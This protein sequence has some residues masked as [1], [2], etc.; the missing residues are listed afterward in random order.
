MLALVQQLAGHA[1]APSHA[2][3]SSQLATGKET[4]VMKTRSKKRGLETTSTS[5]MSTPMKPAKVSKQKLSKDMPAASSACG[6][7]IIRLQEAFAQSRKPVFLEIFAGSGRVC[8]MLRKQGHAALALE[9]RHGLKVNVLSK[10][11]LR[12]LLRR[13]RSGAVAGIWMGTPCSSFSLARRGRGGSPGG[14]LRLIGKY[15]LGHPKALR[16][17]KDRKKIKLGN[18]CASYS[19]R[20]AKAAHNA[21]IPWGLENPSGSRIWHHP[22]IA[23]L[24]AMGSVERRVSHMCA[25]GCPWKKPTAVLCGHCR[26]AGLQKQCHGC[27]KHVILQGANKTALA[28]VYPLKFAKEA[29]QILRFSA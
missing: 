20:Y 29:S 28:Q 13:I 10:R 16:R 8:R 23:N 19:A 1:L 12:F 7:G 2:V 11:V 17:P 22:A 15:I 24:G 9:I 5:Q 4:L 18:K 25:Y 27:Q 6:D 3:S 21:G 14:P 26:G